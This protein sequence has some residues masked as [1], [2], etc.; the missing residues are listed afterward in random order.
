MIQEQPNGF[1]FLCNS[2]YNVLSDEHQ[3]VCLRKDSF[4]P[5]AAD[6]PEYRAWQKKNRSPDNIKLAKMFSLLGEARSM[7]REMMYIDNED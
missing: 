4:H 6:T 2:A 3:K 7:I 1:C 5:H